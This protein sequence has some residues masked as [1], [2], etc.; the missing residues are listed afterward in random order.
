MNYNVMYMVSIN[1]ACIETA[2]HSYLSKYICMYRAS[3]RFRSPSSIG[4]YSGVKEDTPWVLSD[5]Y[6]DS[7]SQQNLVIPES[8]A[9]DDHEL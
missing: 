2:L 4:I 8:A 9:A 7:I 6:H 5:G 1:A 3:N